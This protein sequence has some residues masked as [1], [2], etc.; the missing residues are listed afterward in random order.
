MENKA[1]EERKKKDCTWKSSSPKGKIFLPKHLLAPFFE[2]FNLTN[3]EKPVAWVLWVGALG[4]PWKEPQ[5]LLHCATQMLMML[6]LEF[7]FRDGNLCLSTTLSIAV[8]GRLSEGIQLLCSLSLWPEHL[9]L[10]ALLDISSKTFI[11]RLSSLFWSIDA[12][13]KILV[14]WDN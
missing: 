1:Q 3:A 13:H 7:I 8:P 2:G 4:R 14:K 10:W 12:T 6:L 9:Q 11:Y 5:L